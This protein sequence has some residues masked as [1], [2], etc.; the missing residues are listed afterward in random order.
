MMLKEL[1][2]DLL[3]ST[4]VLVTLAL[5]DIEHLFLY[6]SH[7]CLFDPS[8]N[9]LTICQNNKHERELSIFI[10]KDLF[11]KISNK[12]GTFKKLIFLIKIMTSLTPHD[13]DLVTDSD[14]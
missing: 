2:C 10:I 12:V 11:K 5:R 4:S 3:W 1:K 7:S 14:L 13:V 9:F 6:K 8:Y